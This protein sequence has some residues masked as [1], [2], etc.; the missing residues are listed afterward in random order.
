M[1]FLVI[2]SGQQSIFHNG[3]DSWSVVQAVSTS[4]VDADLS[5]QVTLVIE[6]TVASSHVKGVYIF[7]D[8][9]EKLPI[10]Q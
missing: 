9:I 8:A 3:S 7:I 4:K 5:L 6:H 2:G 1:W 10:Y